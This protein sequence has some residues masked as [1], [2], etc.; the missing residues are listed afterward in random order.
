MT[1]SKNTKRALLASILSVVLCAALLAG[2]TFAWFT[3]SVTNAGNI[4]KSGT[5]EVTME[6]ADGTTDPTAN[7][8]DQW[9]D[10]SAGAIFNSTL[11][12][13]GYTEVRHVRISNNGTLALKYQISIVPTGEVSKLADVIDVYYIQ[14]GQQIADRTDLTDSMKIGTLSEILA[15]PYAAKGNIDGKSGETVYSDVATIALKMQEGAGNEY[16]GRSIGSEFAIRLFATQ[17]AY[18]EDSFGNDYDATAMIMTVEDFEAALE[19]D[20]TEIVIANDI[21]YDWG[22]KFYESSEALKMQGKTISGVTGSET[23]T[24]AGYGSANPITNVVLKNITVKDATTGDDEPAWESRYLEFVDLN[25][26][27]VT[28]EDGIMLSG[29]SVLTGCSFTSQYEDE[30]SVWVYDGTAEIT[31]CMFTGYRGAKVCDYYEN[32]KVTNVV[33]DGCT[34]KNLTKKPGVAIDDHNETGAS[35]FAVTI[36]NSTFAGC[37]AGDQGNY[38]YETDNHVPTLENNTVADVAI[39]N[40]AELVAFAKSVNEEGVSYNG[41]TVI[42]TD[43]IDLEG[44]SWEPIGQTS[45]YNAAIFFQGTFDGQGHTIS[46][47]TVPESTWVAGSDQGANFA[48]G[49]FGFID[50][51]RATIKNVTFKDPTVSG[52]HYV[53]VA[54]GYFTGEISYVNVTGATISCEAVNEHANG[55]KA[56]GIVGYL[57]TVSLVKNCKVENSTISAGRDAGQVVGAAKENEVVDCTAN[58]VTVTSNDSSTGNNIREEVIGRILP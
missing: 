48:S 14:G 46:N 24:F 1:S 20:A 58:E 6:W 11:W 33:I 2:T 44:I 29:T 3:D 5:L 9:K 21:T 52:H 37:Q 16:Q 23:I 4:I 10:A 25:A 50:A 36:K 51:A 55:D 41:K 7:E 56:G 53:G 12:E 34:F 31:D 15:E 26:E 17:Y 40:A 39:G 8:A 38:I 57:N 27:N 45:G 42:L 18:E 30:Y 43:D 35:D 28:F 13:P 54:A 49:F 47:L 22:D 19:S 32:S